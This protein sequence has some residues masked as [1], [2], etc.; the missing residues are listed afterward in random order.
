MT[1]KEFAI[2]A[3]GDQKY[4]E[5]PY[6][7]HLQAVVDVL[8]RF[9][10]TDPDIIA[11]AWLHDVLEDTDKV[12]AQVSLAFGLRIADLVDAVTNAPGRNREDRAALTY[13]RIRAVGGDAVVLKLA[14]RIANTEHSIQHKTRHLEMY[15]REFP[16]FQRALFVPDEWHAMWDHLRAISAE[17]ANATP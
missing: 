5:L 6:A 3:H 14:D 1:A 2:R 16:D 7:T 15:Q 4:G 12:W 17:A 10:V 9:G 8:Y 13:P 11:A